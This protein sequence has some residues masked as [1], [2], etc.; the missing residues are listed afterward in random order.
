MSEGMPL[1][2]SRGGLPY[3]VPYQLGQCDAVLAVD[4]RVRPQSLDQQ[5]S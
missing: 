1:E 2:A 5:V 3:S 4:L